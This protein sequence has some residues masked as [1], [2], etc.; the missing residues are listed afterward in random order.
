MPLAVIILGRDVLLSVAAFYIR[1]TSLPYPVR[2]LK[3]DSFRPYIQLSLP[4]K[5]TFLRYWD[6]SIPSAE[7]RPT[8]ISKVCLYHSTAP[9]YANFIQV[10]TALQLL[11][12]GSTTISPIFPMDLKLPLQALQ[13]VLHSFKRLFTHTTV[14]FRW[15]VAT[16]TI[17]SGLSYV[18]SNDAV[19]IVSQGRNPKN[20][21]KS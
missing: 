15:V 9:T 19:R 12:M 1:Y 3:V 6:F 11:L 13:C 18:F 8:E 14:Y 20:P 10:N 4:A 16:T 17:W 5:K 21:P 2:F 7:V